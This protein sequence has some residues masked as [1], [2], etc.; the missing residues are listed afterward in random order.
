[1]EILDKIGALLGIVAN[2]STI[3]ANAIECAK[4][5]KANEDSSSNPNIIDDTELEDVKITQTT[6]NGG[7]RISGS[8]IKGSTIIQKSG[9]ADVQ[10]E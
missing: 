1:M 5:K 7:N 8:K 6:Q 10:G 2:G 9:G 4:K 3:A